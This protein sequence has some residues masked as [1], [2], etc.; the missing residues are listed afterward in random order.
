VRRGGCALGRYV[1]GRGVFVSEGLIVIPRGDVKRKQLQI[2]QRAINAC[3]GATTV[4]EAEA[5]EKALLSL[6]DPLVIAVPDGWLGDGVKLH[7]PD[8]FD[9]ITRNQ[10]S[11]IIDLFMERAVPGKKTDSAGSSG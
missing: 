11:Q 7:D 1:V 2:I 4:E 6:L 9:E 5:A 3:N 10:L 8:W